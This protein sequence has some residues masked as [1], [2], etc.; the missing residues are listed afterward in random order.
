MIKYHAA[1]VGWLIKEKK[2]EQLDDR[3]IVYQDTEDVNIPTYSKEYTGKVYEI[4][5]DGT[6]KIPRC[7]YYGGNKNLTQI[8]LLSGG[9]KSIIQSGIE[10]FEDS[11]NDIFCLTSHFE[12]LLASCY[13]SLADFYLPSDYPRFK[14]ESVN[15]YIK[16]LENRNEYLKSRN[17]KFSYSISRYGYIGGSGFSDYQPKV[18]ENVKKYGIFAYKNIYGRIEWDFDLVEKYKDKLIWKLLINNS[19]LYWDE[20]MLIK[21]DK[22][23]P[24]K[25]DYDD[26]AYAYDDS[27]KS[28]YL[29]YSKFGNLS[30]TFLRNHIDVLRWS[31]VLEK[32]KFQWNADELTFFS[33]HILQSDKKFPSKNGFGWRRSIYDLEYI[34]ENKHFVWDEKNLLAFLNLC[35]DFWDDIKQYKTLHK[36][37]MSIPNIKELASPHITVD[38]FWET[39]SYQHDFDYD[40]LTKDF[41]IENIKENISIWSEKIESKFITMRRTPDTNY[42]YYWVRTK[43][44]DFSSHINIPLTYEMAKYLKSIDVKIGGTYCESD[45]GYLE[46]D[47]RW[48]VFNGLHLFIHHHIESNEDIDKILEDENLLSDF[49]NPDDTCNE[50]IIS[51]MCEN[52]FKNISL[53]QYLEI[54]NGLK[55]WD[56][57]KKFSS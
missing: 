31:E 1:I 7:D 55:D 44:D 14:G 52:F 5:S 24:Y 54:V 15:N 38:D 29:D 30:N 51:Y 35:E 46:E 41:T 22:Y 8:K 23:I 11:S 26:S 57:I 50:D 19:N 20:D 18:T 33:Q 3:L 6:K 36:T 13:D 2:A 37:F 25:D 17:Y 4:L 28:Q 56:N 43:W 12:E 21:Y 48:P 42:H 34:L 9:K 49:L 45:G 10:L 32:C 40:P 53:S 16:W 39:V 47:H 27:A